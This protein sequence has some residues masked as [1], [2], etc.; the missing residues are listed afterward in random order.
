MTDPEAPEEP[1]A[2]TFAELADWIDGRLTRSDAIAMEH[3][4][5]AAGP[6]TMATAEWIR[7]FAAFGRRH[8]Q[9]AP[10]PIVRQRLRQAFARRHGRA[11]E[12]VRKTAVLSFDSRD[13]AVLSGVRGGFD[14]DE[15]YRLAFAADSLGVLIDVIPTEDSRSVQL[16]GQVLSAETEAPIW[17]VAVDHPG[18]SLSDVGGDADGCFSIAGVPPDARRLVLSNG[19][20]EIEIRQPLGQ[21]EI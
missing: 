16:D 13:D 6:E 17:H 4:V 1:S 18:G 8:P 2:P 5:A 3:R 12:V 9:P 7:R 15:G 21:S 10:P 11:V 19:L 14:I 20:T